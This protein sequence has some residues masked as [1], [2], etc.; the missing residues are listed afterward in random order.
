MFGK[1]VDQVIQ[2]LY[3]DIKDSL[4]GITKAYK[5]FNQRW[6]KWK[7]S[8]QSNK[9]THR[10]EMATRLYHGNSDF[11]NDLC[12]IFN[13]FRYYVD[14]QRILDKQCSLALPVFTPKPI[15]IY[16]CHLFG[17]M[18]LN[19][20]IPFKYF[21]CLFCAACLTLSDPSA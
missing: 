5:H 13:R 3:L 10:L 15:N 14:E 19:F 2:L 8:E 6:Y 17:N 1:Q 9:N 7:C 18:S 12:R 20:I 21:K 16:R 11:E 4:H